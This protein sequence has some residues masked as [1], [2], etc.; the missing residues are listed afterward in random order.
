MDEHIQMRATSGAYTLSRRPST[1]MYVEI[2]QHIRENRRI[3]IRVNEPERSVCL[4]KE[5]PY[6]QTKIILFS[7]NR[8]TKVSYV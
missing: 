5:I 3:I 8:K 7:Y 1:A 2:D 6:G 4:K